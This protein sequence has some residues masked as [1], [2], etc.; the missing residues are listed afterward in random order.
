V[1]RIHEAQLGLP[2][3]VPVYGQI[4]EFAMARSGVSAREFYTNGRLLVE[5]IVE[6]ARKFGL[7]D[8]HIDYDTYTIEA[9]AMGMEVDY[10]D[11]QA[12]QLK[13]TEPLVSE[14]SDLANLKPPVFGE[15][16]RM[17]FVLDVVRGFQ[18]AGVSS[19]WHHSMSY[20]APF[21][22]A[23]RIRGVEGLLMDVLLDPT[24]VHDLLTFVTEAVLI[25]WIDTIN[26]V[27]ETGAA[28]VGGADALAS[29][30]FLRVAHLREFV[31]PYLRRIREHCAD[32][33]VVQNYWGE[34]IVAEPRDLLEFKREAS[35]KVLIVQDP[36]LAK[37]G[38]EI[39][40][41]FA[42]EHDI[43]LTLG[44]GADVITT[45]SPTEIAER[46]K[47]Y[48]EVGKPGG[49]FLVYLCSV[50][51]TTPP[52]NLTAAVAAVREH[53]SYP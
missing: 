11:D 45:M 46:V 5:S 26:S 35:P 38:P 15:S 44:I 19:K 49:R 39:S 41:E 1:S 21:T 4:H 16:G 3:R 10:F 32:E 18:E 14:K 9:E 20:T 31:L 6:T 12:P 7:D 27:N 34:G 17:P 8:P 13:P 33:G 36:D 23:T 53:G 37:V 42:M 51:A 48:V 52:E 50:D 29:P 47:H 43:A 30:P 25:P 22:L 40:K 2:D 28:L 24:F